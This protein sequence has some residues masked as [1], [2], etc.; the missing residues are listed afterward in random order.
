M[1]RGESPVNRLKEREE[2]I[3]NKNYIISIIGT[4]ETAEQAVRLLERV[5]RW[6]YNVHGVYRYRSSYDAVTDSLTIDVM[7]I[8]DWMD[9]PQMRR[10]FPEYTPQ[11]IIRTWYHVMNRVHV[12]QDVIIGS[13]VETQGRA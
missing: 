8:A 7:L 6:R 12:L 9:S 4:P 2:A 5:F 11:G 13:L 10:L 3:M 1:R